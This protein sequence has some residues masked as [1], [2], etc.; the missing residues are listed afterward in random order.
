M[1]VEAPPN[2]RSGVKVPSSIIVERVGVGRRVLRSPERPAGRAAGRRRR[3]SAQ[4]SA[5]RSSSLPLGETLTRSASSPVR[6]ISARPE[7][8]SLNSRL[9]VSAGAGLV[10]RHA[11]ARPVMGEQACRRRHREPVGEIGGGVDAEL[12][13]RRAAIGHE[14]RPGA[15]AEDREFGRVGDIGEPAIGRAC[16][17]SRR[18]RA[19]RRIG[20]PCRPRRRSPTEQRYRVSPSAGLPGGAVG[21]PALRPPAAPAG[22]APPWQRCRSPAFAPA[23]ARCREGRGGPSKT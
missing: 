2:W 10:D 4:C 19:S 20:C 9:A 7:K 23:A 17:S 18:R 12:G 22:R 16:E 1:P 11:V 3:C 8:L 5:P 6:P 14:A 15:G 21:G 13:E